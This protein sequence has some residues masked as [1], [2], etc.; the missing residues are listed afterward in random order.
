MFYDEKKN[1]TVTSSTQ[2]RIL[3]LITNYIYS[4]LRILLMLPQVWALMLRYSGLCIIDTHLYTY[5][6]THH[7]LTVYMFINHFLHIHR[8]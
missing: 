8:I 6:I 3:S 1:L 2:L 7:T 4:H 5:I